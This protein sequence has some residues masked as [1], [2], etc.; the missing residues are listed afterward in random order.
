MPWRCTGLLFLNIS[1]SNYS[2]FKLWVTDIPLQKVL[3]TSERIPMG[4]LLR[5]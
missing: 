4:V 2:N 1:K 3:G 5:Y